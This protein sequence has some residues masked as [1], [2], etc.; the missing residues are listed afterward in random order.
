M[1]TLE[2]TRRVELVS[3]TAQ[4]FV[5]TS[6][7]TGAT[8]PAQ[9]PH[10]GVFVMKIVTRADPE[11]DTFS[12]VARIADLSELPLGRDAGLLS[13]TGTGIEYLSLVVELSYPT[14]SEA[15]Q[16]ATAIKDRVNALITQWIDFK[17]NF[18]APISTPVVYTFPET[19]DSQVAA[20]IATYKAAKQDRYQKNLEKVE[21]DAELTRANTDYTYKKA[22]LV[23]LDVMLAKSL[24]VDADLSNAISFHAALLAAINTFLGEP[25]LVAA[26][27]SADI[28]DAVNIAT[29]E[30]SI[31]ASYTADM[32][33]LSG[34]ISAYQ[35]AR[36]I[37]TDAASTALAAAQADQ[38][39]K[40]QLLVTAQATEAT[41]LAAVLAVCPDFDKN[42][43]PFVDGNEA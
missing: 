29:N 22:R 7:M 12:R 15:I 5:V 33:T 24:V 41:A 36:T 40:A 14:L 1:A 26:P 17:T 16:V 39:S 18:D 25:I 11:D 37:E 27:A 13:A 20:L 32:S 31:L 38:V 3:S 4:R 6:L 35:G 30:T 19:D 9:L 2:Q 10:L 28:Q 43:V 21:A 34:L 23:E 42:S 8:I